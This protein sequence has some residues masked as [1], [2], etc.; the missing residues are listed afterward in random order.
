LASDTERADAV[1]QLSLH[2]ARGRLTL[3]EFEVRVER[4]YAARTVDEL[5]AL[6]DEAA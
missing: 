3:E 5:D 6:L 1:E 4:A 2:C